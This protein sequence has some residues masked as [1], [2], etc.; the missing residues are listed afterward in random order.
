MTPDGFLGV[1]HHERR[2]PDGRRYQHAVHYPG[3]SEGGGAPV[4]LRGAQRPVRH[5]R[6][7]PDPVQAHRGQVPRASG[8]GVELPRAGVHRVAQGSGAEQRVPQLVPQG[9]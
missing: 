3:A 8:A 5:V 6:E 4:P 2:V 1:G 7:L 9:V